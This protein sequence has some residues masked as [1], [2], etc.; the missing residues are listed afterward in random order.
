MPLFSPRR[1]DA[2]PCWPAEPVRARAEVA[3]GASSCGAARAGLRGIPPA[4]GTR[5]ISCAVATATAVGPA[6][7]QRRIHQCIRSRS[8]VCLTVH[9]P[10]RNMR[11]GTC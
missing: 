9:S 3:M 11:G 10:A 1:A 7:R 6:C 2:L 5:S 8:V 4:S